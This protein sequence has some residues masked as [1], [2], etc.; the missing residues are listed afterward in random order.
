MILA[1]TVRDEA[2][3][4]SFFRQLAESGLHAELLGDGEL[5]SLSV[6]FQRHLYLDKMR[7]PILL[8]RITTDAHALL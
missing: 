2:S 7:R 8:H 6:R 1:T 3:V 4:A 5:Q